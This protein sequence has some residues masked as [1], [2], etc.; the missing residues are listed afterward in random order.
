[1]PQIVNAI[2]GRPRLQRIEL[3]L[4]CGR[5]RHDQSAQPQVTYT[6]F[7]AIA[8]KRVPAFDA[9]ACFQRIPRI[10]D[11][12]MNDFGVVAAGVCRNRPFR[13]EHDD[14]STC[15][16]QSTGTGQADDFPA[17]NDAILNIGHG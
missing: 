10:I 17:D 16:R 9:Q 1:M 12:G 3:G 6:A 8:I 7:R 14:V 11:T 13:F 5:G 2:A 15:L 4:L